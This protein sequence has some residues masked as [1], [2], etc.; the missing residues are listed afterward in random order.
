M[1]TRSDI[2]PEDEPLDFNDNE[3]TMEWECAS[4]W[5]TKEKYEIRLIRP[6]L[7]ICFGPDGWAEVETSIS[8]AKEAA[9]Q[10]LRE[11]LGQ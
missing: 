5:F 4:F 11:H 1:S 2:T 6:D 8:G 7:W 3:I 10:H 9:D